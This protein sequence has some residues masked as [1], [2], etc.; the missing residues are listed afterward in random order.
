M[1]DTNELIIKFFQ[2]LTSKL[3]TWLMF[4]PIAAVMAYVIT[5]A[6]Y[7]RHFP[8]RGPAIR[9][10]LRTAIFTLL[11]F[12]VLGIAVSLILPRIFK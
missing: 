4:S 12:L 6:E 2:I 3:T 9:E 8:T 1:S 5:Y 7:S 11:V 10:A